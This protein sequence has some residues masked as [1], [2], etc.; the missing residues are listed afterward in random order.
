MI[1]RT[2]AALVTLLLALAGCTIA[3]ASNGAAGVPDPGSLDLVAKRTFTAYGFRLQS[4]QVLPE[5]KLA[6]ET[7]GRLAPDGRNAVLITHGLTSSGHAAGRYLPTDAAAGWWDGLIGPGKAIDTGRYFVVSSNVLGSSYGSTAPGSID[8]A[9]GKPYGP[10]FPAITMRDIVEAQRLLLSGL[11]VNRLV[12]VAGPSYGGFQAFQWAVAYPDFILGAVVVVS[13]PKTSGGGGPVETMIARFAAD[14]GWNGGRHYDRGGIP[15]TMT[16]LR[17][18]TLMRYGAN[19]L[20]AVNIPD[21]A[22]REARIRQMAAAWAGEFDPNSLIALRRAME[23]FDAER[24]FGKIR[25]RVLYVLSRTDK[26]FPPSIAPG[27][28][29]KLTRAG[30]SAKYYEID[31]EFGHSA[32]GPEWAKWGPAL[33]EFLTSL[34]R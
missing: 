32:S 28:M 7:Y 20:L 26:L 9:T 22:Q 8:P 29:D 27:V 3:P 5:L 33:R 15:A 17:V 25:A 30:V 21:Q 23:G 31:S 12:A 24:D 16:A 1:L 2:V 19:E 11:G 10:D 18:D 14:P 6:Y 13:A 4:G 34:E